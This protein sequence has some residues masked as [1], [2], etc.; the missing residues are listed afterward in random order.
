[1]PRLRHVSKVFMPITRGGV[2]RCLEPSTTQSRNTVR[3]GEIHRFSSA[4]FG[5]AMAERNGTGLRA[6]KA[7][8]GLHA[9]YGPGGVRALYLK[10]S[11]DP[12]RPGQPPLLDPPIRAVQVREPGASI[13]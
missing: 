13:G 2:A 5:P 4:D 6:L 8:E 3:R 11:P 10:V 1:M 7:R 9:D 12:V